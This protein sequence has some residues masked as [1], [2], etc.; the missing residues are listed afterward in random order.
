MG[1][2]RHQKNLEQPQNIPV[3]EEPHEEEESDEP[4]IGEQLQFITAR[5]KQKGC[6]KGKGKQ[7]QQQQQQPQQPSQP[8]AKPKPQTP[9][10]LVPPPQLYEGKKQMAKKP[11]PQRYETGKGDD[12]P[13]MTSK[14]H[15]WSAKGAPTPS[16]TP[17]TLTSVESLLKETSIQTPVTPVVPKTTETTTTTTTTQKQIFTKINLIIIIKMTFL[18]LLM[19]AVDQK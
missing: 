9:T 8:Q 1:P 7:Q 16:P 15:A 11:P 4:E 14:P 10:Q 12:F 13:E 6:K 18:L 2:K 3:R 17:S 19:G 5:Q